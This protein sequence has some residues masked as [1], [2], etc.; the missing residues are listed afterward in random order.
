[1]AEAV[2]EKYID[3]LAVGIRNI[4][5]IFRPGAVV[6]A[7]GI[8]EAGN[9]L[10]EPLVKKV[11]SGVPIKIS[12]LQNDAGIIGAALLGEKNR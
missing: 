9:A 7:G 1:M 3:Y 2:F 8:S 4:I 12:R 6:I 5:N 11:A 10:L